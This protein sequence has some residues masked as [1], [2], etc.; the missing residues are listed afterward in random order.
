MR[1][2]GGL[3]LGAGLRARLGFAAA[4]VL[5]FSLAACGS[6]NV[7]SEGGDSNLMLGGNDPVA[8]FAAGRPLP[9]RSDIKTEHRGLTYRFASDESRRQFITSPERYVPQFGGFCAQAMAYA[10]PAPADAGTFKIIDGKLY[11]FASARARLYFEMDQERNLKLAW[12]YWETEVADSSWRLQSW[13]RL[14]F[15]V[16]HYKSNAELDEEYARRFGKKPS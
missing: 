3:R 9:G 10:V 6:M 2:H 11:L 15:R 16:P 7:V 1:L 13:K 8:Y 4:M 14:L 5:I 12:H